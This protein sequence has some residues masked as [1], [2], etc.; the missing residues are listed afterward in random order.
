MSEEKSSQPVKSVALAWPPTRE[1][2]QRLYVEQRLSA[3]KIAK[4]YGLKYASPKTAESTV[5]HH[6]KKNGI[7]RRDPAE[8]IRKVREEMVNA[9]VARYQK[10]ESLKQIAGNMLDPVTVFN[11]LHKRGLRLRDKVEAQ[12]EAVIIHAKLPF[13]GDALDM[14]YL[15][16]LAAGDFG[17]VKHGRAVRARLGTT[18]PAMA[19]LFRSL[20]ERHGPIYEYPK[21]DHLTGYQWS[22]DCDLDQSFSFLHVAKK[23]PLS[24]VTND[25]MF[26]AFLAGFFDAEG[27]IYYHAKGHRGSFELSITNTNFELLQEIAS[28]LTRLGF[29]HVLRKVRVDREKANASGISNPSEIMWRI[30]VWRYHDVHRILSCMPLRHPEKIAKKEIA[31]RLGFRAKEDEREQIL[32]EWNSLIQSILA[33]CQEYVEKAKREFEMKSMLTKRTKVSPIQ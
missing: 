25:T 12:I 21:L 1:D 29:A 32:K 15:C 11:H 20:L 7:R 8:H 14:A 26:L 13:H 18:H 5:L 10:G 23:A 17:V 30:V 3:A 2:L 4:I 6:L 33:D 28:W 16:G 31:L 27:S 24:L 19:T 9:W 22:L